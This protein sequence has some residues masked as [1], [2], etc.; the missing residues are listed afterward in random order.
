MFFRWAQF[1]YLSPEMQRIFSS[2]SQGDMVS[3]EAAGRPKCEEDLVCTASFKVG[4]R[5]PWAERCVQTLEAEN[6]PLSETSKEMRTLASQLFGT[7]FCPKTECVWKQIYPSG[8]PEKDSVLPNGEGRATL[9][10]NSWPMGTVR[11]YICVA[12]RQRSVIICDS[13]NR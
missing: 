3:G 12:L 6:D 8:L 7:E 11:K 2:W 4:R 5:G 9:C 13:S 1:N 10:P